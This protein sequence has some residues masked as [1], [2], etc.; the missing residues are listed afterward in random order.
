VRESVLGV[1]RKDTMSHWRLRGRCRY[2]SSRLRYSPGLPVGQ[3]DDQ[4]WVTT[5]AWWRI[6]GVQWAL[7]PLTKGDA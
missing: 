7:P 2:Q 3:W 6:S 4:G 5:W 1:G